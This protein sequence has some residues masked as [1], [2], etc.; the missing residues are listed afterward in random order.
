YGAYEIYIRTGFECLA[1]ASR[2]VRSMPYQRFRLGIL[3][4]SAIGG[5]ILMW[6]MD[7]PVAIVT[8]AAILGGVLAC[9]LWCFFMIWADRRFLPAPLRMRPVLYSLVTL[10]GVVLTG[11]GLKAVWDYVASF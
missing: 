10:A 8:P 7:D 1:P 9:G 5:L 6:T 11:L 4:Y 2:R 3:L